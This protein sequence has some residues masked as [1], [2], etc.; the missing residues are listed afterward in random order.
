[1]YL[2]RRE[3]QA[4]LLTVLTI[5]GTLLGATAIAGLLMLFQIR[6]S[7]DLKNSNKAI[8]AADSAIEWGNYNW[9]VGASWEQTSPA[10]RTIV[11]SDFPKTRS[12]AVCYNKFGNP[13]IIN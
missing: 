8:Y 11:L 1:M 10:S 13:I 2:F 4:M 3:G 7:T 12:A 5:G 6:Q 9:L